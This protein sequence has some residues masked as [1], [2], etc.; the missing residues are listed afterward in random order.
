M[1]IL[2]E[3]EALPSKARSSW[4]SETNTCVSRPRQRIPPVVVFS[5]PLETE[6]P[7]FSAAFFY[8]PETEA[9]GS[10]HCIIFRRRLTSYKKPRCGIRRRRK[11]PFSPRRCG[12]LWGRRRQA[13]LKV[14]PETEGKGSNATFPRPP[15]SADLSAVARLNRLKTT[16]PSPTGQLWP[17]LIESVAL[18]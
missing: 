5:S 10:P 9:Y 13:T 3:T 15:A 1:K 8:P 6:E 2:P 12:I 7:A 11:I 18:S 17:R 16:D 14:P 4:P